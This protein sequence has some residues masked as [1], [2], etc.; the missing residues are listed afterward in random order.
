MKKKI[1]QSEVLVFQIEVQ[2]IGEFI[3]V[4]GFW[5]VVPVGMAVCM[6]MR[7]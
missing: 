5:K 6:R 4:A 2:M 1:I 7:Q 3:E